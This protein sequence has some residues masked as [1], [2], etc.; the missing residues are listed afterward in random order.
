[1]CIYSAPKRLQRNIALAIINNKHNCHIMEIYQF[2]KVFRQLG[3]SI[4]RISIIIVI[5]RDDTID[6]S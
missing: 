1:M 3:I 5:Q 2:E 4:S 6:K